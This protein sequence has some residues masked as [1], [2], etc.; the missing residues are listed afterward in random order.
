MNQIKLIYFLDCPNFPIVKNILLDMGLIFEEVEQN[1]LPNN[2]PLKLLT[3][4]SILKDD[5][6]VFGQRTDSAIGGC[7]LN[8]PQKADL[9][10]RLKD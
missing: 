5:K 2:Q 7:S 6:L 10:D 4:P 3:S 1:S 9:I 8:L